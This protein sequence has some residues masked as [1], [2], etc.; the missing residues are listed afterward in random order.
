MDSGME[1][2]TVM[3]MEARTKTSWRSTVLLY[4]FKRGGVR[5]CSLNCLCFGWCLP[6][7]R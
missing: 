3:E 2:E 7:T 4:V 5:S 1:M 6:R